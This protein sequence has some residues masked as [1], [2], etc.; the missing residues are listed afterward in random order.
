MIHGKYIQP[1]DA[2]IVTEFAGP[3]RTDMPGRIVVGMATIAGTDHQC[4][5][6]SIDRYP[7][8][9]I[10]AGRAIVVGVDM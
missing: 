10:V 1:T 4:M 3:I 8:Q 9:G 6:H 2:R 7:T 5:V